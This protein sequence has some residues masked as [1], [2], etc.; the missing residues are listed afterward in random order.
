MTYTAIRNT[1]LG[2][3]NYQ[4]TGSTTLNG[5]IDN[6]VTT[7][8]VTSVASFKSGQGILLIDSELI[9]Y[10]GVSGASF[11]GCTRG[12]YGTSAASH[13]T[14]ATVLEK[15]MTL[16]TE[17]NATF[18]AAVNKIKNLSAFWL[19]SYLYSI[20]DDFESY[21]VG[22]F[23]TNS[24]W[25]VTT[26]VDGGGP[27]ATCTISSSTTAGG[28]G[29][30]VVL[31]VSSSNTNG[32][33]SI[34]STLLK[35]ANKHFRIKCAYNIN[36]INANTGGI[37]IFFTIGSQ[38]YYEIDRLEYNGVRNGL[39]DILVVAKGSNAY[40]VYTAGKKVFSNVTEATPTLY[41]KVSSNG[42]SAGTSAQMYLDDAYESQY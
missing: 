1:N 11:T 3:T 37:G 28:S 4:T 30:E 26:H 19:N 15:E 22:A 41:F 18:D 31:S 9:T 40:D 16:S 27:T 21:S 32:S 25:T 36:A 23:T 17:L 20:Y 6:V 13:L 39:L 5:G 33:Y 42:G 35:A 29:K 38:S 8:P 34:L 24:K 2:G 12:T 14:A 7:I 10:T